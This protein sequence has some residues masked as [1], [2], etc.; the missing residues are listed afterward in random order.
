MLDYFALF[1]EPR[2]PW[3]EAA[4]LREKF[5]ARSA[6]AHPDKAPAGDEAARAAAAKSFADLNAAYHC[7][8]D[9]KARLL[10]LLEL[11]RGAKP[12]DIQQIPAGL[13]DL[14][15][16]VAMVCRQADGFL[17]GKGRA[18]SPLLQVEWFERSQE[19]I[20][21]LNALQARLNGLQERLL[22]ELQ[23]VDAEWVNPA[24][25]APVNSP[26][27]SPQRQ[28]PASPTQELQAKARRE[29]LLPKLEELYRLFGYFNRWNR[30][31][32][33]RVVQLMI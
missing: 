24:G 33:E 11:E 32:Q 14:F 27:G 20:E 7:L 22:Q 25:M 15:A 9:P 18:T 5:F 17:A 12:Q 8:S 13:A 16:E 19:W 29:A 4:A 21:K 1:S 6:T 30:Q 31:I 23:A 3:L 26:A 10:H 28:G 2:R